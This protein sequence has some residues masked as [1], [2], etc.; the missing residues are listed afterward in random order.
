MDPMRQSWTDDRMDELNGK[1]DGF[2]LETRTE[3]RAVRAEVKEE[4]A[5][6]RAEMKE[7]FAAV[8]DE[9]REGFDKV[10]KRFD[11]VDARFESMDER[12]QTMDARL[13]QIYRT[14]VVFCGTAMAALIG[15]LFTLVGI[16][17]FP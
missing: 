13:V 15:G 8:R 5:A 3:F 10:D 1:V 7:E 9:M 2:R 14:M 12:F 11:K 16:A 6:V 17:L 4:F